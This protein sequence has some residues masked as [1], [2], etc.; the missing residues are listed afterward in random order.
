[1]EALRRRGVDAQLVVFERG[2]LHPEADWSL[3]RRGGFARR[4]LSQWRALAKLL[5]RTDVF[6]FYFGL[7]LVP[8]SLQFPI[9][10]ATGK[11]SVYHYLG[12]DIRGKTPAEL[13]YGKRA[14]AEIVGSYDAIRW[15][16]EAEVIPPGIDLTAFTPVPPTDRARPL[17]VHAPSHRGKKGTEDVIA[18]CEGLPV[19]LELVEG[20]HHDEARRRYEEADIVVD[21]LNAGWY[22]L[23]AIEAMALGKPVITFL[24]EEAVAPK[25]RGIRRR[26]ADRLGHEGHAARRARAPRGR[27][28]R[29]PTPRRGRARVRRAGPRHRPDRRPPARRLRSPLAMYEQLKRLAKHSGIYG[30]GGLVQRLLAV[31]LL[32][33]YTSYLSTSDYGQIET[34]VAAAAVVVIVLR[35]GISSAFF[36]FYFDSDEAEEKLRVVRTSFWYT[37]SAA[38]AGLI[39]IV[40]FASQIS[41]WLHLGSGGTT[42]VYASAVGIWAQMNYE[43]LTSLFRVEERSVQYV[44]ASIANI[45]I[46]VGATV[47]LV[48]V[49]DKGPLGVLVG[50]FIGTLIV[51]VVL[52]GYHREQLGLVFDRNL[53]R[54][55]NHF[56]M[57]LVP[58]ALALWAINFIDRWF[59]AFYKGQ[60]EV[61]VYSVA[62]RIA[63]AVVFL[64]LAFRTAWPA[65][66]YSITEDR[67]AKR[68][69]AYV[70]TYVLLVTCWLAAALGLL[71]PWLVHLLARNPGFQR[72]SE[73]VG[74]LAFSAAIFAGYT[75]LAIGS[76]RARRTQLNWVI[77][78]LA[79]VVNIG[80]N[81]V[82]IPRYGMIGAA[83]STLIAYVVLFF[84]MLWYAQVVYPVDYQWRRV[85]T[86]VGVAAG[87]ALI[88]RYAGVPLAVAIVLAA[89]YPLLLLAVGFFLPA[90]RKRLRQLVPLLR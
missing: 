10:S 17:V 63:S 86:V 2:T 28:R 7:T 48:V 76:G 67:D 14:D 90:E 77:S 38:T 27:P 74:L 69:Y 23:F 16:P 55:M 35:G 71:A 72:A 68:A 49:F 64:L 44:I 39:V 3:D 31:I 13:A 60:S 61:G 58:S 73:A 50:N 89:V 53:F 43:Q 5:P 15:V 70:L 78:A 25:R 19:E 1:M 45:L 88:G 65:F 34:L 62:V 40:V 30:L 18:A 41:G 22:G 24:H 81:I 26:G 37:M 20:L 11:K 9:L 82:L 83:I 12:S 32:P 42:L 66:A 54:R 87:L 57:P 33:L 84:A 29:A 59:V 46:T 8:K 56:G 79:A 21:Q 36:R 6:H 85:G 47:L 51:Y 52:V 80:L 75:V 4:Q